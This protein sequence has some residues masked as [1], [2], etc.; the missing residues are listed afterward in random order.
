[1]SSPA[2]VTGNL[3]RNP[4]LSRTTDATPGREPHDR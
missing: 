4:Q 1:M 2:Y 3:T